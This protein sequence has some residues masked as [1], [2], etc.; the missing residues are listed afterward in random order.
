MKSVASWI[1]RMR[2]R[3]ESGFTLIEMLI[4]VG[5]I[6]ALAAA[7]VPQV[8]SFGGKGEE[9]QGSAEV[10]AV[11]VAMDA[12]MASSGVSAV[13]AG[14][15]GSPNRSWAALPLKS[16]GTTQIPLFPTYLRQA[17]T[18]WGYCWT[19]SGIVSQTVLPADTTC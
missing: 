17:S 18:T 3:G 5:I 12:A 1:A 15:T 14:A 7:I 16:D 13:T 6:V 4:V 11:Q 2:P 8:V 19:T 10:S 9:G